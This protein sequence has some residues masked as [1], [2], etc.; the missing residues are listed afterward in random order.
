[1]GKSQVFE[2]RSQMPVGAGEVFAWHARE[3][4]FQRLT[5]PWEPVEVVERQGD[6]I[7]EGTRVVLRMK[8][9]P[10]S[11]RWVARHTR[12]I[13]GSL[14]QDEQVSGPFAKW[15]HTHRMWDEPAGSGVLEDE[16]EYALPVGALGRLVGGGYA[17][18]RLER[19]FAYRHTVTR[20]D[21]RRH[22]AFAGQPP[23]TVA[24]SGASGLVG[25]ALGPFLTTGGHRVRRLVRGRPEAGDIAWAPGQGEMDMVALEG[26][27][28]VVHLA[29]APIAEGRWT[30]ERKALIRRSRVEGTR[31][32]CESLARLARP[33]KVLVC[34]SA[35][36]FYG[37]RGDEVLTESSPPGEGFLADVTREWE[38]A[39]APAEQAGIRVVHLRL[40]VVL[41]A[42]GGALAKML[43]AFQA[44]AGGRIGD[45][46]Q[47]MSW[48]SLED[49][50]GLIHF[51]LF[52]PGLRGPVNAVAPQAVR[53]EAFAR[54]L[55]HVLSRPAVMPLPAA[56]V[57]A[58]FGEM[59]EE[60]LLLSS[61]V[62][63]E[64]AERQGFSF[65][66]PS[67][68]QTLRFTLGRTSEGPRFRHG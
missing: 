53:Q 57:R 67:L 14:F 49:L 33:P 46:Q 64:V 30:E 45:G 31:V 12:Y 38:A 51:A 56:A 27:D 41:S 5:P 4:A 52:T 6:G 13:P 26:V 16:V 39:S 10:V 15:V 61:H 32:L 20:E 60:T 36:G 21:L 63:P 68:E 3:G 59:G 11:L 29:G 8:T 18:G 62:R 40:G 44:G 35:M 58:A 7:R 66:H 55:G 43:P 28:A 50:L 19:M 25:S 54:T 1:M 42:R 65:L 24:V 22:A 17:R 48:V 37:S 23:L 2:A 9:G 34:A 47:W